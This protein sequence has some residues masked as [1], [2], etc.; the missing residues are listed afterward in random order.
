MQERIHE[1]LRRNAVDEALELARDWVAQAPEDVDARRSLAAVLARSGD[2]EGALAA[3]DQAILLA[4]EA[5]GLHFERAGLLMLERQLGEAQ[6]ALA[7]SLGLDPNLFRAYLLK[8]RLALVE[9][10]LEEAERLSAMAGRIVADDPQ[11]LV[12]DAMVALRRGDAARA[13]ALA[14]R[15]SEELPEDPQALS[16][17]GMAH[18]ASQ[19]W[20]FAEQ[21]FRR[22]AGL[23]PD[24]RAL[25]PVIAQL[26]HRQGRAGD[27]ADLLRALL[28]DGGAGTDALRKATASY[29]LDA[30]RWQQ[31]AARMQP[32]LLADPGDRE[33]LALSMRAWLGGADREAGLRTLETALASRPRDP[34]LWIARLSLEAQGSAGSGD[35]LARWR[36]A[37]PDHVPA[38][39]AAL[40][41][42]VRGGDGQAAEAVARRIL[43]L[44]PGRTSGEQVLVELQLA[45]APDAALERAAAL[46]AAQP[47]PQAAEE[48]QHWRARLL[49]RAGRTAEAVALWLELQQARTA[50]SPAPPPVSHPAG[51]LPGMGATPGPGRALL[52][53]GAPGSGI[54]RVASL[55]EHAGAPV[56]VDRFSHR[57][58]GDALQR[59]ESGSALVEGGLEPA[60]VVRGWRDALPD[61]GAPAG[62]VIDWLPWWDNGLLLALRPYLPEGVLVAALRDPRDMLLDW[63]AVGSPA[64]VAF[65]SPDTAAAW[66]ADTLAQLAGLVEGQLYPS[67]VLRLD[68]GMHAPD[69]LATVVGDALGA[70]LP[71]IAPG[72]GMVRLPAGRWRAYADVLAGPFARL[73]PVA[74][75]LGYPET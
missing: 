60:A 6:A 24:A 35:V 66:L 9:G 28:D 68:E 57:P 46:A 34:E 16:V 45:D 7:R 29:E 71:A 30:G 22:V 2:S 12:I 58:P 50:R 48:L 54:E 52:L 20:A 43:E 75:R 44:E 26:V 62:T 32:V 64:P 23:V 3:L 33:A 65:A 10:D 31:A 15:A 63:L 67:V 42:A 14:A 59:G 37:M 11:L 19:H 17:L 49:D 47:T 36:E 27:A 13:I 25:Q 21:A 8:A 74:A 18:A 5:A 1:A 56:L 73:A 4:P 69:V 41:A 40:F 55:L 39:E 51:G 70:P 53:W 61:R 38:L 72:P